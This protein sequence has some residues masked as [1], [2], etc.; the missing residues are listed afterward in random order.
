MKSAATFKRTSTLTLS[1]GQE[2][3]VR[4]PDI[5]RLVMKHQ[6]TANVPQPLTNMVLASLDSKPTPAL[7]FTA[8]D[9]PSLA[10]FTELVIKA[11]LVW[12]CVVDADPDYEAGEI[13]LDD[14]TPAER[15]EIQAWAMPEAAQ[16][17][18]AATFPEEQNGRVESA[19]S[20]KRVRAAS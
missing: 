1:T 7:T 12:P 3:E 10:A 8:A 11:A 13:L 20:G 5:A 6:G 19:P 17:D 18:G 4:K 14:L 2:V 15:A 9:L 16:A